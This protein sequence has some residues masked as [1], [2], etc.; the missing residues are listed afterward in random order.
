LTLRLSPF[1]QK[2]KEQPQRVPITPPAEAR[3]IT[4]HLNMHRRKNGE[5]VTFIEVEHLSV[6][7][8]HLS[9]LRHGKKSRS[10]D[11][12]GRLRATV[13]GFAEAS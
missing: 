7:A 8:S 11:V 2:Q 13:S 4:C 10:A 5:C 6:E 12:V 3:D 9:H 1:L